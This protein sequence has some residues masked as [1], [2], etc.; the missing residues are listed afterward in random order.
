MR[1]STEHSATRPGPGLGSAQPPRFHA[2]RA[3]GN[4]SDDWPGA[5]PAVADQPQA[6]E[7]SRDP[8]T[9]AD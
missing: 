5:P 6:C 3:S 9:V 4:G 7:C 1:R 8:S 2:A